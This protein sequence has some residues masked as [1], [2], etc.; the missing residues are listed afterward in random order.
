MGSVRFAG[1]TLNGLSRIE[2]TRLG[3]ARSFQLPRPFTTLTLAENLRVPIL[4]AAE[5]RHGQTLGPA[6]SDA[7]MRRPTGNGRAPTKAIQ[8]RAT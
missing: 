2:R 7:A 4:Y 8:R 3:L 5:S 6:R 1:H